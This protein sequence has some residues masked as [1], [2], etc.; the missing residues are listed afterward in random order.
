MFGG[1]Y[2]YRSHARHFVSYTSS[3]VFKSRRRG[4]RGTALEAQNQDFK[5]C[6]IF[7]KSSLLRHDDSLIAQKNTLFTNLGNLPL[8]L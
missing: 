3:N 1:L 4:P 5:S 2:P 8:S 6:L 7:G